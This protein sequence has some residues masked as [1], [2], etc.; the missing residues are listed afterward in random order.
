MEGKAF[1]DVAKNLRRRR[2]DADYNMSTK[3]FIDHRKCEAG[4]WQVQYIVFSVRAI[5]QRTAS[6]AIE[7]RHWGISPQNWIISLLKIM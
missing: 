1:L 3:E 5:C 6:S 2:N 4:L 7:K